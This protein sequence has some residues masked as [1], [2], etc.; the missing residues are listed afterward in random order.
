M[1]QKFPQQ[2][3]KLEKEINRLVHSEHLMS[4]YEKELKVIEEVNKTNKEKLIQ[5]VEMLKDAQ[6][7]NILINER[8]SNKIEKEKEFAISKFAT[9]ILEILDNF[10]LFFKNVDSFPTG[11]EM[12]NGEV[13]KGIE[14]MYSSAVQ[15]LNRFGIVKIDVKEGDM[16][17]FDKHDVIFAVPMPGKQENEILIVSQTG[18]MIKERVLRAAKVGVVKNN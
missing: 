12:R 8:L 4:K 14:L 16:A 3:E 18:Y 6:K 11:K 13:F 15:I 2:Y 7:E 17:D 1:K 5:V 10:D 9:N